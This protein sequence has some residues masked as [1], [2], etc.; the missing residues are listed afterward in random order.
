MTKAHKATNQPQF[1]LR[2]KLTI[3]GLTEIQWE[4]FIQTLNHHSRV[5]FAERKPKRQLIVTFDGTHWSTNELLNL[6]EAQ[7]GRL[8]RGWWQRQKLAWYQ[9]TDDNLSAN[10][11]HEPTCCSKAP[12][13]KK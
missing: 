10:A 9:F 12:P 2:R 8:K 11:K 13:M 5:D 6:I 7:G 1:L 4:D 3:E